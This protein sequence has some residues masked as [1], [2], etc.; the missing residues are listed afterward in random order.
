[1]KYILKLIVIIICLVGGHVLAS[2]LKNKTLDLPI[3]YISGEFS[4]LRKIK[5]K[6]PVYLKFWAS[7][8]KPCRKQMPHLQH[9]YKTYGDEI[10]VLAVNLGM[11]DDIESVRSTVK[12]FGL[13]MPII[14][15][16]TG[17]LSK[18]FNVPGTPYHVLLDKDNNVIHIGHKASK[19]LNNKIKNI[20]INNSIKFNDFVNFPTS[21]KNITTKN[22]VSKPNKTSALFFIATWCDS[23][24]K[25]SRPKMSLNCIKSQ[26][27]V[28]M[29][30]EEFPQIAW[31]GIVSHLWTSEKEIN[32]FKIKYNIKYPLILDEKNEMFIK[33]NV[34]HFPTLILTKNGK[35]IF[36]T[37]EFN[38]GI[39]MSVKI[40]KVLKSNK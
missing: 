20:A 14:I 38:S 3:E 34:K 21:V 5:G 27:T 23:Y 18:A 29:L 39:D 33:Y 11:N 6:K 7:W 19:K 31:S 16:K 37:Q 36:K 28:N 8:C 24:L 13:T 15:D 35:N 9:I 17:E 22:S 40:N 10:K 4:T 26:E 32:K 30:Y 25:D 1:M 12:E 2:T